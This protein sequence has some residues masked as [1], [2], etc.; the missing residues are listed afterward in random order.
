M[1]Q[2]A[3]LTSPRL[4]I[5]LLALAFPLFPWPASAAE[6]E[7][8]YTKLDLKQC[9]NVTPEDVAHPDVAQFKHDLDWIDQQIAALTPVNTNN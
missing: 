1:P 6:I 7:S 2:A 4:P 9:K 8:V 5:L 3:P